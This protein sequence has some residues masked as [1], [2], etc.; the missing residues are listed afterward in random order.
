MYRSRVEMNFSVAFVTVYHCNLAKLKSE[1]E[2][3]SVAA[4]WLLGY[5]FGCQYIPP[6][7]LV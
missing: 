2:E 7:W 3:D 6:S 1:L 4:G 5:A